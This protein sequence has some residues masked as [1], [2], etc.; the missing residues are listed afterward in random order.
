MEQ[1]TIFIKG[2]VCNRCVMTVE[3]ELL[4]MGHTP[5]KLSLGEVSFLPNIAHDGTALEERLTLLGFSLL[6]DKNVK[7]TKEV[8]QLVEEVYGG[9]FDFP[10]RFRFSDLVRQRLQKE[11][12]AVSDAF[13]ATEKKTIEQYIIDFRINK[14][15]EYLVYTDLTLADIAFRLNFNSVAHLSTQFKQQTGLTPSFFKSIRRQKSETV[16]SQN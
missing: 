16:F 13:I 2:M 11:Y 14:I 4:Q 9:N 6:E 12:D 15:K 10:E 1:Q 7:M 3:T 8:K 5:V